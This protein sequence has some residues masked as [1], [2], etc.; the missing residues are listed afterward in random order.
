MTQ[1]SCVGASMLRV[2][3]GLLTKKV[4][5]VGTYASIEPYLR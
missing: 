4:G 5:N 3:S 2:G 1:V